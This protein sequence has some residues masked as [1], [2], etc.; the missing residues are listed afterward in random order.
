MMNLE[1]YRKVSSFLFLLGIFVGSSTN[2]NLHAQQIVNTYPQGYYLFPINPGQRNYFSGTPF[3]LRGSHFHGGLDVKTG[4]MVGLPVRAAADGYVSRIKVSHTGYGLALYLTH[5]NGQSTVYAHLDKYMPAIATYVLQEQ[6]RRNSFSIDVNLSPQKFPVKKGDIIGWSG[7]S[8]SS[9][10]PHLHFEIRNAQDVPLNVV[11]F[12]F[13]EIT[14]QLPPV[15]K[16]IAI[17]PLDIRARVEQQFAK[18]IY[19]VVSTE[20]GFFVKEKISVFGK[21][22]IEINAYDVAEGSN[23]EYGVNYITVEVNEKKIYQ[24]QLDAI[25]FEMSR[26]IHAFTDYAYWVKNKKRLQRLYRLPAH[27]ALPI[28]SEGNGILDV[29]AGETYHLKIKVKDCF[30]NQSVVSLTL[31]GQTPTTLLSTPLRHQDELEIVG[32]VLCVTHT[33][34]PDELKTAAVYS[35][36]FSYP[37]LPAYSSGQIDV[38]LWNLHKGLPDSI[39]IGSKTIKPHFKIMVLPEKETHFYDEVAHLYFSRNSLFDTLYLQVRWTGDTLVIQNPYTPLRSSI[40]V[41]FKPTMEIRNKEKMQMLCVNGKNSTWLGGKWEG[42]RFHFRTTELGKFVV[43]YDT[44]PPTITFLRKTDE[45]AFYIQD[46]ES[47][48]KSYR[49]TLNGEWL[50][51]KYDAKDD[52]LISERKNKE[53]PLKGRFVLQVEDNAGN[54]TVFDRMF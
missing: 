18:Q 52:F 25:P 16:W 42:D 22:G 41:S 32:N 1:I 34:K 5:P 2:D 31:E 14:D 19:P 23:N 35:P 7:N 9:T 4:N 24:H 33:A 37:L 28:F 36:M 20:K 53:Q 13:K 40:G 44:T 27:A 3:E 6:Y 45:V 29:K 10:S 39:V 54:L 48:I 30:G 43:A 17:Q 49:A 46:K 11:K 50:L 51:M 15:V 8:G 38:Y 47:G 12:G 21:I 26:Y